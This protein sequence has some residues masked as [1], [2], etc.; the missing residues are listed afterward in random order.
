MTRHNWLAYYQFFTF[1][2]FGIESS[3]AEA[4][5]TTMPF[6]TDNTDVDAKIFVGV[7]PIND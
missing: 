5:P 4:P 6:G 3:K 2:S 7:K 1:K